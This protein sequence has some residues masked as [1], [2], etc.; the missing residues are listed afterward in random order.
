MCD[1]RDGL[2]VPRIVTENFQIVLTRKNFNA[3]LGM[4][5]R[6]PVEVVKDLTECEPGNMGVVTVGR[7]LQATKEITK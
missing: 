1:V 7:Q 4:R 3:V 5:L 6:F 2:K